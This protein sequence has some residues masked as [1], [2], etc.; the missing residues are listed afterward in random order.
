MESP[1]SARLGN[2]PHNCIWLLLIEEEEEEEGLN[3]W[4][5][6]PSFSVSLSPVPH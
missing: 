6:S 4:L 5:T 3:G 2:N 1:H